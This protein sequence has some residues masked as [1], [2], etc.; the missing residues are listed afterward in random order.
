MKGVK[1][2]TAEGGANQRANG[3][4]RMGVERLF[5]CERGSN[6]NCTKLYPSAIRCPHSFLHALQHLSSFSLLICM[7]SPMKSSELSLLQE[8]L[9]TLLSPQSKRTLQC[10]DADLLSGL[11]D[12]LS[13][14]EEKENRD[15]QMNALTAT[16]AAAMESPIEP[17]PR[18]PWSPQEKHFLFMWMK[19]DGCIEHPP[20]M[21]PNRSP[22]GNRSTVLQ[23]F[24]KMHEP[25]LQENTTPFLLQVIPLIRSFTAYEDVNNFMIGKASHK[26]TEHALQGMEN[27]ARQKYIPEDYTLMIGLLY[28]SSEVYKRAEHLILQLESELH[29]QFETYKD[30]KFHR[31]L[32]LDS[33]GR[34]TRK[35]EGKVYY[36]TLYLAIRVN[37]I[38]GHTRGQVRKA[39]G[40]PPPLPSV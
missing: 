35:S 38:K 17:F 18:K 12:K 31:Q 7:T 34:M 25:L 37:G 6:S 29:N 2:T 16:F 15:P 27:R 8:E 9:K 5:R 4:E 20:A 10:M 14:D 33:T 19:A 23:F 22:A 1:K 26:H 40:A 13:I 36:Y 39:K 24:S 28:L 11:L 32:S 21:F 30:P 3:H